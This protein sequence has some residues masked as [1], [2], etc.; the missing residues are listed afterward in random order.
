M[1]PSDPSLGSEPFCELAPG[2]P[3]LG[4]LFGRGLLVE[5]TKPSDCPGKHCVKHIVGTRCGSWDYATSGLVICERDED[6]TP[7]STSVSSPGKCD[8]PSSTMANLKMCSFQ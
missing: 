4:K 5:C 1:I 8:V 2:S 6:C 3:A 7:P